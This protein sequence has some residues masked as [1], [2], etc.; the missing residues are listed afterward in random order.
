MLE[1]H[2]FD[3]ILMDCHM[4][5]MDGFEATTKII[6]KYKTNRPQIIALTASSMKADR[7]KCTETGMDSFLSKPVDLPTLESALGSVL[8]QKH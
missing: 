4:P 3:V 6:E 8:R 1:G 7:D 2:P 5:V